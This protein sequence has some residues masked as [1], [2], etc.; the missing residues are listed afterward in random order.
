MTVM[1]KKNYWTDEEINILKN[2]YKFGDINKIVKLLPHRTYKAITTK[3]KYLGLKTREYWSDEEVK[4]LIDNYS[5]CCLD[6]II[7][8]FPNRKR[9]TIITKAL[10]LNL[11]NKSILDVRFNKSEKEYVFKNYNSMSDKE[12]GNQLGRTATAINNYRYRNGLI[13]KYEKSS[14][15]DLSEYIRRNNA[16]WKREA[17]VYCNYKCVIT[18]ERFDEIHHIHGLNLILNETLA[19]L[20]ITLKER[21]DD[22][23]DKELKRILNKFRELQSTYPHGVC[24]TKEIHNLFHSQYGYGGNTVEQWNEFIVNYNNSKYT[25]VA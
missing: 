10:S 23:S 11:T 20:G 22:Y 14:Y 8:M 2:N 17:M 9:N 21:I 4:L 12:I 19:V 15:N 18:G 24:L 13:K 1:S 6:D 3:A 7:K 5:K 16:E 25:I